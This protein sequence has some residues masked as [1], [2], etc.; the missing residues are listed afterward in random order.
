[1]PA[2]PRDAKGLL[3]SAL[4][5]TSPVVILEHRWSYGQ[6]GEVPE[7]VFLEPI[8]K[9]R[10]ARRGHRCTVVAC[11]YMVHEAMT[12]AERL[13]SRGIEVEVVDLRTIRPWDTA[14]V[15]ESVKKTGRLVVADTGWGHFGVAAEISSTVSER[16]F[17]YLKAPVQR[18][19]LPDVPTPCAA[20]LEQAYY[21]SADDIVRAVETSLLGEGR[22]SEREERATVGNVKPF[23]GAF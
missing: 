18:V 11:S 9:A 3:L 23:E 1:M 10:I 20:A 15:L 12:A 4:H 21:P 13:A 7:E 17:A 22:A 16:A 2:T 14:T 6:V 5:E 19:A 8:G